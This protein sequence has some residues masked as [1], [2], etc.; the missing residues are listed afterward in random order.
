MPK[1]T[2]D[3]CPA[4]DKVLETKEDSTVTYI[5]C[6]N[7]LAILVAKWQATKEELA[8]WV[9][10]GPEQGGLAAFLDAYQITPPRQ[11]F[12]PYCAG[13]EDYL[14]PLSLWWFRQNDIEQFVPADRYITGASLIERWST[15][16][17]SLPEDYIIARVRESRLVDMHPTFGGTRAT[18]NDP[19]PGL[20]YPPVESGL[21]S[22]KQIEALEVEEG[23]TPSTDNRHD[24]TPPP[25]AAPPT[26]A[27]AENHLSEGKETMPK[28]ATDYESYLRFM[29]GAVW[30]LKE[31]ALRLGAGYLPAYDDKKRAPKLLA[32][33]EQAELNRL[34]LL[35]AFNDTRDWLKITRPMT[36]ERDGYRYVEARGFLDWLSQYIC[37]TQAKE[38]TF[39]GE[40]A[41][42]IKRAMVMAAASAPAADEEFV[43]LT[44]ALDGWFDK[45]WECLPPA[46]RQQIEQKT[47]VLQFLWKTISPEQRLDCARQWDYRHDPATEPE[48]QRLFQFYAELNDKLQEARDKLAE[49]E[50][51]AAP[52]AGDL[53][54]KESH[55]E[56]WRREVARL[57]LLENSAQATTCDDTSRL[58]DGMESAGVGVDYK[59]L[60]GEMEK[61]VIGPEKLCRAFGCG[62]NSFSAVT[63]RVKKYNDRYPDAPIQFGRIGQSPILYWHEI[64]KI[65]G[66]VGGCSGKRTRKKTSKKT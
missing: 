62:E 28:R 60:L 10:L 12:Y 53:E 55:I 34:T 40:L 17:S 49:W 29:D 31:D 41:D 32:P 37:Q 54:K 6:E 24:K 52:D 16:K 47:T 13:C 38:F 50:S 4:N 59:S 3:H 27:R 56:K 63:R 23:I 15:L 48:R 42:A 36:F 26:T 57:E 35:G 2:T 30:L 20:S 21:F 11:F 8:A 43:S 51:V 61:A 58:G 65:I 1:Q 44:R 64:Y 5:S 7:A 66:A 33:N 18:F 46:L 22:I 25:V 14:W 39:P 19:L 45:D 9:F